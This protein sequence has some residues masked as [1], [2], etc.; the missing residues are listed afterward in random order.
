MERVLFSR[1]EAAGLLGI[2]VRT[3]F[4]LVRDE[5]IK[6]R[7][8]RGRVLIPA[9]EIKRFA[10]PA[11]SRKHKSQRPQPEARAGVVSSAGQPR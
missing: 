7:R 4:N 11:R 6:V 3:L 5:E 1:M 8:V 9:S 2:G 10:R